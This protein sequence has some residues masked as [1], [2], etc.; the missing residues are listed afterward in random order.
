MSRIEE[1]AE[2]YSQHIRTPWSRNVAGAQ[3]VIMVVYDKDLERTLGARKELFE[4]ATCD[5]QHG[6]CELDLSS[7]FSSWVAQDD[8]RDAYFESPDDL[9]LKLDSEFSNHVAGLLRNAISAP[10]MNDNSVLAVYGLGTLFGFT[11][12]SQV[13][14]LIEPEISGRLVLFFPGQI[15][16]NNFRLLDARDGWNYMAVVISLHSEG[17]WV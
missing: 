7:A 17:A 5:A 3:R 16:G 1:L 15:D 8:Y 13:I 12:I 14:K 11:S 6:W 2:K 10:D 4:I 9:R